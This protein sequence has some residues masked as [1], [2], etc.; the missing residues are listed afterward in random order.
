MESINVPIW[1]FWVVISFA[2]FTTGV[3]FLLE[4]R[5]NVLGI[6]KGTYKEADLKEM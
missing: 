1:P 5:K 3:R 2:Y 6:M 4:I